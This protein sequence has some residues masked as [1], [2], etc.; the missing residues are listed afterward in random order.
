VASGTL[1]TLADGSRV[2]V[3]SL[4]VGMH[5]MSYD[6]TTH[7]FVDATITRF[8]SVITNNQMEIHTATGKPLIVDQNPAQKL[9]AMFP[10]DTWTLLP[11][12]ELKIGYRLFNPMT[13]TWIPITS[14]D[15]QNGGNHV[16]YDIYSSYPGNYIANGYLD[17]L[18]L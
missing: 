16:M 15:Y 10:N 13:Q 7:Q 3:Q 12:T 2:P 1:I 11:V 8:V 5:V 17:P 18:K 14:I 9:Y 4:R 6:M